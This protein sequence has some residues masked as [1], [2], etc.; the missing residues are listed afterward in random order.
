MLPALGLGSERAEPG[1]MQQPPRAKNAHLMNK[2]VVWK[3]FLWYGLI[4]SVVSTF[5][6]FF[7]NV[8]NGW[9]SIALAAS[10]Q[11]YSRATTMVLGAIVFSQIA[12][13]LNCRT[14]TASVMQVGLFSNRR[15]WYG[16]V[17]EVILFAFLTMTPGVQELFNTTVLQGADWLFLFAIPIPIF[18]IEQLRKWIDRRRL[19]KAA[20]AVA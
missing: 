8:Q 13:A 3:A 7:V 16:I 6:Y 15:V 9:P 14:K 1:I 19:G 11:V 17:F 20:Q 12:N 5:A 2:S 10:G 18:L 4:S